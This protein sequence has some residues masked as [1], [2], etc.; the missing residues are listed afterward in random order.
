[1][2]DDKRNVFLAAE[3]N[4]LKNVHIDHSTYN[5]HDDRDD[6]RDVFSGPER[7]KRQTQLHPR[8]KDYDSRDSASRDVSQGI[9]P[10]QLL[11]GVLYCLEKTLVVGVQVKISVTP[12]GSVDLGRR[13]GLK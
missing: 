8:T 12:A 7:R 11:N 2:H 6:K 5:S 10:N 3:Q 4:S 13:E 9:I 1:M